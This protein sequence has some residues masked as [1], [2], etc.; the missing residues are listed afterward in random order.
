MADDPVEIRVRRPLDVAVLAADIIDG[1]IVEHE[2]TAGVVEGG[3][4]GENRIVGFHDGR[5]D[6]FDTIANNLN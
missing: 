2:C 3:M 4:S 1:L 6:L 5:G